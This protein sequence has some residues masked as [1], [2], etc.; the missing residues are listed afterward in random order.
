MCRTATASLHG[1]D[2]SYDNELVATKVWAV[3]F[4][5]RDRAVLAERD[6]LGAPAPMPAPGI[7]ETLRKW[8]EVQ[9]QKKELAAWTPRVVR[10]GETIPISGSADVYPEGT[11]ERHIVSFL[12]AWQ[13]G[14][15]GHMARDAGRAWKGSGRDESRGGK[16]A[17]RALRGRRHPA[18]AGLHH[19]H[20]ITTK[21]RRGNAT[22]L[23]IAST[24]LIWH[25]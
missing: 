9:E 4:A 1:R 13:R 21:L 10:V 23:A 24:M 7:M 8:Q 17:T 6:Q 11:P 20:S 2:L 15:Y 16:G 18:K 14:N 22:V 5:V 25:V 3:L 12:S 19:A